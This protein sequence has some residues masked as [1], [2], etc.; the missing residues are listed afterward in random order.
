M[1]NRWGEHND[2]T[3]GSEHAKLLNIYIQHSYKAILT[4]K[5]TRTKKKLEAMIYIYRLV[6]AL[7]QRS[8]KIWDAD[9]FWLNRSF[10]SH[11]LLLSSMSN[12]SVINVFMILWKP[13]KIRGFFLQ[14]WLKMLWKESIYI[15]VVFRM[16]L[17]IKGS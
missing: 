3:H 12:L 6:K 9:T 8:V 7:F 10:E 11:F 5:H 13:G 17:I 2:P 16:D 14:L 4:S 15:L 1:L